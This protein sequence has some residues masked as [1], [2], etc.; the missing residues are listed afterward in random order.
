MSVLSREEMI[1]LK[2]RFAPTFHFVSSFGGTDGGGLIWFL[3]S[4]C[5]SELNRSTS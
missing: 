5:L 2:E 1:W 3:V 4:F